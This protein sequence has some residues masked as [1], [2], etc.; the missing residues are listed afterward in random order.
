VLPVAP[1][2]MFQNNSFASFKERFFSKKS[3]KDKSKSCIEEIQHRPRSSSVCSISFPTSE[4]LVEESM[5]RG[6]P[7]IPFGFPTFV[8]EEENQST[9]KQQGFMKIKKE[10]IPNEKDND[11]RN[12]SGSLHF[13][14]NQRVLRQQKILAVDPGILVRGVREKG[15]MKWAKT[16]SKPPPFPKTKGDKMQKTK[17]M[18][19]KFNVFG[20]G[21][22]KSLWRKSGHERNFSK[23]DDYM[24]LDYTKNLKTRNDIKNLMKKG[25]TL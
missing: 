22:I 1:R 10:I 24:F 6:L 14:K 25:T 11:K 23:K 4:D 13:N 17:S 21:D 8:I 20:S 2:K 19:L 5:A 16:S 7:I 18:D 9:T 3:K 15:H 12:V